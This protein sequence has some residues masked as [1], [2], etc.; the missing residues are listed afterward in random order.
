MIR[1]RRFVGF[2]SLKVLHIT[3]IHSNQLLL[4]FD[5]H[6]MFSPRRGSTCI[7]KMLPRIIGRLEGLP[8]I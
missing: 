1:D 7:V 5:I 6:P 4:A 2:S 8:K 3:Y